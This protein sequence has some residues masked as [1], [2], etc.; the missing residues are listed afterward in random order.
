MFGAI[1]MTDGSVKHLGF[2]LQNLHVIE[3]CSNGIG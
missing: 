1:I 2:E 3:R